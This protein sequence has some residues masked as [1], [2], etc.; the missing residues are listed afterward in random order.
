MGQAI[1][2]DGRASLAGISNLMVGFVQN[3]VKQFPCRPIKQ[4]VNY[5]WAKRPQE[6]MCSSGWSVDEVTKF[7]T[8]H[9]LR[10]PA[11]VLAANRVR[12]RDLVNLR[13]QDFHEVCQHILAADDGVWV[14]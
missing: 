14:L 6:S 11:A 10:G 8:A 5:S 2:T 1:P 12:G 4:R 9:D 13:L 3:S 7:F